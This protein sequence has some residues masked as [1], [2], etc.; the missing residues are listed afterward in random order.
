MPYQIYYSDQAVKGFQKLPKNKALDLKTK[1]ET[2]AKNPYLPNNNLA[3][4][5]GTKNSFR[6]RLGDYRVLYELDNRR[7]IIYIHRIKPRG[8]VYK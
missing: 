4:L 5:S 3:P 8:E 7:Q 1:L 6:L 2:L